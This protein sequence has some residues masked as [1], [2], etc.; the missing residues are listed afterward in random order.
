MPAARL[1]ES[2]RMRR[3]PPE[4]GRP[5]LARAV[6][7]ASQAMAAIGMPLLV[8]CSMSLLVKS[9]VQERPVADEQFGACFEG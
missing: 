8:P 4:Q 2:R 5:P 9:S 6:M 1:A 7:A 3:S